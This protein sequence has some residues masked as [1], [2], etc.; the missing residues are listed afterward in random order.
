MATQYSLLLHNQSTRPGYFCVYA[1][2]VN[3]QQVQHDLRTLAWATY[4]ANPNGDVEF[5][6]LMNYSF[7]WCKTGVLTNGVI[8][9]ASAH[10]STD[11][12]NAQ[13]NRAY[14][15]KNDYG[16]NLINDSKANA[17]YPGGMAITTSGLI[18]NNDVSIGIGI[19]GNP[20]LAVLATPNYT[21]TFFPDLKYWVAFGD[22]KK[23]QVLDLNSMSTVQELNFVD[24]VYALDIT[25][26]SSNTWTVKTLTQLN[27]EHI[28]RTAKK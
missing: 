9:K 16:Y 19:D 15:D 14:L 10:L 25:L 5:D 4:P 1:T 18:V 21:F 2:A 24:N 13:T 20:V 22:Y 17:P 8:Y 6:W 7:S 28:L 27:A 11:P 26:S 12:G 3:P 23:G